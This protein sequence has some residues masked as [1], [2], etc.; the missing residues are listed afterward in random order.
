MPDRTPPPLHSIS[1]LGAA[2]Q[3]L[4]AASTELTNA[5]VV[6]EEHLA[7][8]AL[9]VPAWV[10]TKGWT[11]E[12]GG[13]WKREL[14]YDLIDGDWHVGI[15]ETSGHEGAPEHDNTRTWKFDS[16]PRKSR[17]SV[18]DS[19]PSLL[20]ALVKESATTA[21]KMRAKS[22][23]VGALAAMLKPAKKA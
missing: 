2:A 10:E 4:A 17:I 8:L 13:F 15:K 9:G 12:Y 14:G 18:V 6:I 19:I 5:I 11:D 23:E 20:T 22:A 21:R 1:E 16:A 7:K 3:D